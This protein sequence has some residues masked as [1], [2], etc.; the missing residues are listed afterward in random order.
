MLF[1][2]KLCF[3]CF[4]KTL[5]YIG[6]NIQNNSLEEFYLNKFLKSIIQKL[7]QEAVQ[8]GIKQ[9]G[10]KVV[11]EFSKPLEFSKEP[12]KLNDIDKDSNGK[13][14][15]RNTLIKQLGI[16]GINIASD[17]IKEK[18]KSTIIIYNG[19]CEPIITSIRYN[20][21]YNW[22]TV[23]WYVIP[24]KTSK[25]ILKE[26]FTSE[27]IYVH[28][29]TDN[30]EHTWQSNEYEEVIEGK[31]RYFCKYYVSNDKEFTIRLT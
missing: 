6:V 2:N 8:E 16:Q 23:H 13:I 31:M 28:G 1:I 3:C 9:I 30:D 27:Y 24:S 20:K 26:N 17:V 22:N 7:A 25:I 14:R 29:H 4:G 12:L 10:N 11:E 5:Y 18:L 15:F 19:F 21:E